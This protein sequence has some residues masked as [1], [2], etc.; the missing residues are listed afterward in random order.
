MLKYTVTD[1]PVCVSIPWHRMGMYALGRFSESACEGIFFPPKGGPAHPR[2]LPTQKLK[3]E[4][5][6]DCIILVWG[7][8][9]ASGLA[10]SDRDAQPPVPTRGIGTQGLAL[11]RECGGSTH[12]KGGEWPLL[13][14]LCNR[15]SLS[16][17]LWVPWDLGLFYFLFCFAWGLN[18]EAT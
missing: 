9:Q 5:Q 13:I 1:K 8:S 10:G 14:C 12:F 15:S 17:R 4:V 6:R 16:T 11:G 2:S 18:A 3:M 7:Q